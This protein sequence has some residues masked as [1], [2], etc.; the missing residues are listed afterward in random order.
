MSRP[1]RI[2]EL[3]GRA[4][5]SVATLR[6]YERRGLLPPPARNLDNNYRTYFDDA[7]EMVAAIKRAQ[8]MGFTLKEIKALVEL[9]RSRSPH[10]E[11]T[12]I[13]GV[14][15]GEVEE[16][17]KRVTRARSTLKKLLGEC[18]RHGDRATTDCGLF[19]HLVGAAISTAPVKSSA[20]RAKAKR[21]SAR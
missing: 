16:E 3:A 7:I 21:S 1:I 5:V 14:K 6:F 12:R 4:G 18:P 17:L 13:A 11:L 19:R 15:L 2:G 10:S 9:R 20:A 8:E